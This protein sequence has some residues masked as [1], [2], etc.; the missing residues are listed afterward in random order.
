MLLYLRFAL[1]QND[2]TKVVQFALA[3][4]RFYLTDSQNNKFCYY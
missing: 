3:L 4:Y 1:Y 2:Q